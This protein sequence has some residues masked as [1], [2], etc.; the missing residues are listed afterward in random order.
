M[1]NDAIVQDLIEVIFNIEQRN[2]EAADAENNEIRG[3]IV[4][5]ILDELD[6]VVTN[7]EN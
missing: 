4:S 1:N 2:M 3:R 5:S 7:N 6:K